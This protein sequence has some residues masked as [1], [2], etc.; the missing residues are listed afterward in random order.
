MQSELARYFSAVRRSQGIRLGQL[1]RLCGYRSVS[2]GASRLDRFEKWNEIHENLLRKL[3][4]VLGIDQETVARLIAEDHRRYVV[5]WTEWVNTPIRPS[6]ILGHIGGFCWGEPL[7]EGMT[8]ET[9][10]EYAAGIAKQMDRPIVLVLS[11]RLSLWF[12]REGHRTSVVEAKP[13]DV[14]VPYLRLG[15]RKVTFDVGTGEIQVLDEPQQ[16]GPE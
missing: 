16:P 3:A 14:T 9:A 11:R 13:G 15:R 7:P 12:D 8:R 4:D 10:E 6:L 2:K 5:A 1:A